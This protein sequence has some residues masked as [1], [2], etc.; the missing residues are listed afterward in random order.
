MSGDSLLCSRV[1]FRTRA[2]SWEEADGSPVKPGKEPGQGR[3]PGETTRLRWTQ[4]SGSWPVRDVLVARRRSV[5][6]IIGGVSVTVRLIAV[7]QSLRRGG[8]RE[9]NP[10]TRQQNQEEKW[11]PPRTAAPPP[12]LCGTRERT[13]DCKQELSLYNRLL[14]SSA[15][16]PHRWWKIGS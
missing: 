10:R 12:S 9:I 8:P 4:V 2:V 13:A 6:L 14:V 1:A 3:A 7:H 5:L 16:K 15:T 11:P